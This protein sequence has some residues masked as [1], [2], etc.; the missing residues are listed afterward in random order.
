VKT[1]EAPQGRREMQAG[2][3]A[4]NRPQ[5]ADSITSGGGKELGVRFS[6]SSSNLC[7]GEEKKEGE[8]GLLCDRIVE[9][10]RGEGEKRRRIAGSKF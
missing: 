10:G 5:E 6:W 4:G 3:R 9:M 2:G 7:S 8:G 1:R